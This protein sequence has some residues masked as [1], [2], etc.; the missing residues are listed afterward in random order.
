MVT[1]RVQGVDFRRFVVNR[2]VALRLQGTAKNLPDGSS[3]EVHA[4][5]LRGDLLSLLEHLHR[6]PR[7]ALVEHVE[8]EW[9]EFQGLRRGFTI[10]GY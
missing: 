3:L 1:G 4:E 5:G 2:A 8:T 6:G 7:G 9:S 10:T